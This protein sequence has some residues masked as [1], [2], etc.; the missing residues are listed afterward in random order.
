MT[1]HKCS[2]CSRSLLQRSARKEAQGEVRKFWSCTGYRKEDPLCTAM[3]DD[4]NDK[5]DYAAF[6]LNFKFKCP[7]CDDYLSRRKKRD[8]AEYFWVCKSTKTKKQC[9]TFLDDKNQE[10]DFVKYTLSHQHKCDNCSSWLRMVDSEKGKFWPCV[11][12]KC[13]YFYM[14]SGNAPDRDLAKKTYLHKCPNCKE[15]MLKRIEDKRNGGQQWVCSCQACKTYLPDIGGMP[16]LTF[17]PEKKPAKA[18]K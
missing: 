16:D 9:K 2:V 4:L 3:Y 7:E 13:G 18:K 10:P 15:G 1:K 8:K 11:N 17:K 5:P 14:D 6:D 12:D